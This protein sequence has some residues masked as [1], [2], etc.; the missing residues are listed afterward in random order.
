MKKTKQIGLNA[1]KY[2]AKIID[3]PIKLATSTALSDQAVLHTI[4]S[5]ENQIKFDHVL[6]LQA[7][8]P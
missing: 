3:R 4:K 7:T 1:K 8:C 5:I 2:G 6:Y